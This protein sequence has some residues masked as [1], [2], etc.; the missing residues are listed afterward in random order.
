LTSLPAL[1]LELPAV[2]LEETKPDSEGG[3]DGFVD[4]PRDGLA[5]TLGQVRV[6]VDLTL[7]RSDCAGAVMVDL[8]RYSSF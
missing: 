4:N 3:T 8:D 5:I 1:A 2:T 7:A 6:E